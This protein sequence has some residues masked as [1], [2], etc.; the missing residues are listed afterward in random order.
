[1]TQHDL[2]GALYGHRVPRH[3]WCSRNDGRW[4][5]ASMILVGAHGIDPLWCEGLVYG[6]WPS[7][8]GRN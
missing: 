1:M 4:F 7:R 2:T 8:T 5:V 6:L 3:A